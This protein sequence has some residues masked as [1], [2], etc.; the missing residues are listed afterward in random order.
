MRFNAVGHA[1]NQYAD[2]CAFVA[3]QE[4]AARAPASL[5]AGPPVFALLVLIASHTVGM[6]GGTS[7]GLPPVLVDNM[8]RLLWEVLSDK[9]SQP[10][11]SGS[12]A[13]L[14]LAPPA[15]L[16]RGVGWRGVVSLLLRCVR[17]GRRGLH[18]AATEDA[19]QAVA[20]QVSLAWTATA[21]LL[22]AAGPAKGRQ[23]GAEVNMFRLAASLTVEGALCV[24]ELPQGTVCP[25][26]ALA[27]L[28]LAP[29]GEHERSGGRRRPPAVASFTDWKRVLGLSSSQAQVWHMRCWPCRPGRGPGARRR[30]G[31]GGARARGRAGRAV[32]SQQA[33]RRL[34]CRGAGA[35]QRQQGWAASLAARSSCDCH[36]GRLASRV[37]E[38]AR[39]P[40]RSVG[41]RR[42]L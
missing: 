19:A 24:V 29:G 8:V 15:A 3:A 14:A 26:A 18:L 21:R 17:A 13:V 33:A 41:P 4:S 42:P 25:G 39:A 5:L 12:L 1:W 30:S 36:G 31:A 38:D 34:L 10:G 7:Y 11:V 22:A 28:L 20:R 40:L 23:L 9:E 27:Q 35:A 37:P 2:T 6:D 16:L 32:R